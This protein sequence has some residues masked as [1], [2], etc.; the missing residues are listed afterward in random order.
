MGKLVFLAG[1]IFSVLS[2]YSQD[3]TKYKSYKP[4]E[5][6]KDAIEKA[7]K[8]AKTAGKHVLVQVGGNWCIW[9]ARFDDF[10]STDRGL[11]SLMRENYV[12]YHLNHSPENKN[13]DLLKKYEFPQRFGFP[14]FLV[15]NEK[16]DLL[17]TQTS[18]YLEGGKYYNREKVVA[19]FTDWSR[20]ALDP[21]QYKDQ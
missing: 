18:W 17:H 19:F 5:D 14:V 7:V 10:V 3:L 9:C 8:E 1:V 13:N 16:G 21:A 20:K 2:G 4:E 11:D 6:A 12:I 15:L